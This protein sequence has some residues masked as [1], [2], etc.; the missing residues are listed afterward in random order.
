MPY[1][2]RTRR[3][4]V[5]RLPDGKEIDFG[6]WDL[7]DFLQPRS[8][9]STEVYIKAFTRLVNEF[10]GIRDLANMIGLHN[11]L[12]KYA[13]NIVNVEVKYRYDDPVFNVADFWLLPNETWSQRQGDCEDISFL[14]QS[15]IEHILEFDGSSDPSA[16]S[17][18]VIGYYFDGENYYGHAWVLYRSDKIVP[19]DRWAWIE[20]TLESEVPQHIWYLWRP[21]ELIPVYWFNSR[22]SYMI[23]ED[24][25]M[26]GLSKDY[27]EKHKAMIEAMIDYVEVGRRLK[28]KW[29]HKGCR[30]PKISEKLYVN[31]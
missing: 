19:K 8:L 1:Y 27:V 14:L 17:Y 2:V 9:A 21:E 3:K 25:D 12:I 30:T 31:S 6:E 5:V 16:W 24:H 11:V 22:V 28:V 18:A 13:W 20:T 7:R 23:L 10:V 4:R 29:M 15:V 26:L